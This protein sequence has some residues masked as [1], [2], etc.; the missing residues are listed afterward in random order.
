MDFTIWD[1]KVETLQ[2]AVGLTSM[3][4]DPI[5]AANDPSFI[6]AQ[7]L[8]TDYV[9][10]KQ[11]RDVIEK[12]CRTLE[13]VYG[14]QQDN[15]LP[16]FKTQMKQLV[17]RTITC[18][19]GYVGVDF[20]RADGDV[21]EEPLTPVS[22]QDR[23]K[24]AKE[25]LGRLEL[26]EIQDDSATMQTLQN[27]FSTIQASA[28]SPTSDQEV[29]ERLVFTFPTPTSI[30]I[31]PCCIALKGFIGAHWIAEQSIKTVQ[32]LESFF[33]I[34]IDATSVGNY[35]TTVDTEYNNPPSD[36]SS[37][38]KRKLCLWKVFDLDTK[39]MFYI[40]HGWKEFHN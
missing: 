4:T 11:R 40:A 29:K 15:Q 24:T 9:Q 28:S 20:S 6:A 33:G 22:L 3:V 30:I 12:I 19:V 38:E 14:W 34:K 39:S 17:R 31:D 18:G 26:G 21:L 10:G 1:E 13:I 7:A 2:H 35:D 8:I 23:I 25:I 5:Q 32:Q 36:S 27:L 37:P 16:D